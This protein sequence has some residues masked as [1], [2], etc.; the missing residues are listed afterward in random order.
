MQAITEVLEVRHTYASMRTIA[1][2]RQSNATAGALVGR[3]ITESA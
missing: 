3:W 1:T 2:A